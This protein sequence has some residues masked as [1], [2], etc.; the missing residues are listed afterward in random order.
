MKYLLVLIGFAMLLSGCGN[1]GGSD[2]P[3]NSIKDFVKAVKEG[4]T[5]KAW[6][7]L[8]AESQKQ[9]ETTA[10]ARNISGKEAFI[11]DFKNPKSLGNLYED[12]DVVN[13][14]KEGDNAQV[15]LKFTSGKTFEVYSIKEGAWKYDLVRTNKEMMKLVE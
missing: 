9:F 11:N 7:Y 5:E 14:K 10:K 13:E 2:S 12:F 3:A 6:N 8:S 4:S 1:S 15:S